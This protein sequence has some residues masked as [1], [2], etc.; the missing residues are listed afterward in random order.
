MSPLLQFIQNQTIKENLP[1][2]LLL[3]EVLQRA[4]GI[5]IYET[6]YEEQILML[7]GIFYL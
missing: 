7:E 5:H 4:I 6:A 1:H 3:Q 2:L